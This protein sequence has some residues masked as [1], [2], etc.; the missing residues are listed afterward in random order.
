MGVGTPVLEER[1]RFILDV[2][3]PRIWRLGRIAALGRVGEIQVFGQDISAASP[4]HSP[5]RP[6][7]RAPGYLGNCTPDWFELK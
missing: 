6:M 5:Y 3:D 1:T 2:P 4:G 7:N